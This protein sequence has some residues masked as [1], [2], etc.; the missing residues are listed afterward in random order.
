MLKFLAIITTC[1]F[2][3]HAQLSVTTA[4]GERALK[5]P[6]KSGELIFED[7]FREFNLDIWEHDA[8]LAGGGNGEFQW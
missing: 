2:V 1:L 8:T 6:F 3:C 7:N 5:G 4:S